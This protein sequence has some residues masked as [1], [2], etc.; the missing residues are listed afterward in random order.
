MIK[1][2]L[3][4]INFNINIKNTTYS[5]DG[6]NV[7]R[8]TEILSKMIHED[9]L[10]SWSNYLGFKRIKYKDELNKA[11]TIGSDTH[12]AIDEY[13]KNKEENKYNV[14]FQAFL[15]WWNMLILNNNVEIIGQE[16]TL[17]CQWFGGTYDLLLKI[18]DKI[19][20]IDFKTSNHITY[21]Y[22]LQLAAYRHMI[23]IN[24]NINIDG[25]IILQ[26][27]KKDVTFE[28][29]VLDFSNIDHYNFIEQC[30]QSF[31]SLVYSYY[32]ISYTENLYKQ[33]F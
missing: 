20:L 7:P 18:N 13:L 8:V 32:N 30:L 17:V 26:L 9:Y 10:M 29:F 19:Y 25:C 12:S 11:A 28:E 6:I 2:A 27:D 22:F 1:Q 5:Y 23:Y 16:E 21:K 24:K 3:E 14:S 15:L 31:L 4:S 33:I